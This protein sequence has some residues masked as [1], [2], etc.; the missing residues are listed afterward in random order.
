MCKEYALR[1]VLGSVDSFFKALF[2]PIECSNTVK[3]IFAEMYPSA[4]CVQWMACAELLVL[5]LSA[6]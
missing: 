1:H 6:S 4:G 3:A 5:P 2:L